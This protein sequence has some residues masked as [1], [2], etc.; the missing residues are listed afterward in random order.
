MEDLFDNRPIVRIGFVCRS[1]PVKR[2]VDRFKGVIW[3]ARDPLWSSTV[4]D[5]V[6][7]RLISGWRWKEYVSDGRKE[8]RG[9]R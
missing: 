8:G 3:P 4:H 6:L 1:L 9:R 7:D 2:L 5:K